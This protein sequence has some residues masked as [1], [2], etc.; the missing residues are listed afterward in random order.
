MQDIYQ[1]KQEII[2]T[3]YCKIV[4]RVYLL[5]YLQNF[6]SCLVFST[7]FFSFLDLPPIVID[8]LL[9]FRVFERVTLK[10]AVHMHK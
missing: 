8:C 4:Y 2:I 9:S 3:I 6:L 1:R 5:S 7:R 10:V